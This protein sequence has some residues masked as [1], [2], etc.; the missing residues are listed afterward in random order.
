[1]LSLSADGHA[2]RRLERSSERRCCE[3]LLVH[4]VLFERFVRKADVSAVADEQTHSVV[5]YL[6]QCFCHSMPV[7]SSL[8]CL[9]AVACSAVFHL[10][11]D[12]RKRE[13][14]FGACVD[15]RH[16]REKTR[17]APAELHKKR[18][19]RNLRS[20]RFLGGSSELFAN[21]NLELMKEAT[22]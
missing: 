5:P 8:D 16:P 1:M 22:V 18:G 3:L 7:F 12:S 13:R 2:D 21:C 11:P 10:S 9:A 15:F 14:N 20:R 6:S 4:L 17:S 19:R